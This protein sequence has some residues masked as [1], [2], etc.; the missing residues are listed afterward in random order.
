MLFCIATLSLILQKAN[1]SKHNEFG[2]IEKKN[3]RFTVNRMAKF[4]SPNS[5]RLRRYHCCFSFDIINGYF[6]NQETKEE[7]KMYLFTALSAQ[8]LNQEM[9]TTQKNMPKRQAEQANT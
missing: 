6:E 9:S 1:E 7:I 8:T 4:T 2:L 5:T 3:R